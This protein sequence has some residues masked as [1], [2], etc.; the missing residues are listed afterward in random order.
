MESRYDV[1]LARLS[2]LHATVVDL[3][4]TLRNADAMLDRSVHHR[5]VKS[6]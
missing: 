5:Q 2:R 6:G 3:E 1:Q 4:R